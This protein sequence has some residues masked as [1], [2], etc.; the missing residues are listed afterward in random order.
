MTAA[1]YALV[2]TH[3]L[4]IVGASTI[5]PSSSNTPTVRMR[6]R[7]FTAVTGPKKHQADTPPDSVKTTVDAA[8]WNR[9]IP[10]AQVVRFGRNVQRPSAFA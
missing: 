3:G 7:R 9:G 1:L 4:W 8:R 10:K 6:E 5:R 2:A